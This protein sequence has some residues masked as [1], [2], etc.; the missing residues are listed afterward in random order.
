[1]TTE[2]KGLRF[3][4]K[5]EE[6]PYGD[7]T[8]WKWTWTFVGKGNVAYAKSPESYDTEKECRSAIAKVRSKLGSARMA[9]V[10]TL[11]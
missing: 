3:E 5:G 11:A 10:I 4:V 9:K 6:L 7:D 2:R 8:Y 1:M